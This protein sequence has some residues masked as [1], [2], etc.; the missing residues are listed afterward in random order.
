MRYSNITMAG[1]LTRDAKLFINQ[2]LNDPPEDL[3]EEVDYSGR[4]ERG[5]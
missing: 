5:M 1:E 2:F 4:G 3:Y